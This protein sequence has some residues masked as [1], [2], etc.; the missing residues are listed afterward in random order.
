MKS[1]YEIVVRFD[2]SNSDVVTSRTY[3]GVLDKYDAAGTGHRNGT[4]SISVSCSPE[5]LEEIK[6]DLGDI[7][8]ISTIRL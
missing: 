7:R 3:F 4:S 1:K 2:D 6:R 8:V 5:T